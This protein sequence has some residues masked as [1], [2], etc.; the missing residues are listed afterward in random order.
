MVSSTGPS[1]HNVEYL[2]KL[3][4]WMHAALPDVWDDHLFTIEQQ[5]PGFPDP[6]LASLSFSSFVSQDAHTHPS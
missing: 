3:A 2:L 6:L 1:G 4:E 5:V